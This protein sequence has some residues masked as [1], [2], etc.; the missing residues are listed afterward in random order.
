MYKPG[1]G[2]QRH[3]C[4]SAAGFG[5]VVLGGCG[6]VGLWGAG[7]PGSS[8]FPRHEGDRQQGG[9]PLLQRLRSARAAV[10]DAVHQLRRLRRGVVLQHDHG[11]EGRPVPLLV[12][13]HVPLALLQ[14][15]L[16]LRLLLG[17]PP[18]QPLL[19]LLP[20]RRGH[21]QQEGAGD[22][23]PQPQGA[24]QVE[25][26]QAAGAAVP[27]RVLDGPPARAVAVPAELRR[28]HEPALADHPLELPPGREVVVAAVPLPR[29]RRPGGVRHR[30]GVV[31]GVP[32]QQALADRAL[33]HAA[34]PADHHHGVPGRGRARVV[35]LQHPGPALRRRG[36]LGPVVADP[37][38]LPPRVP[39]HG[40][41]PV[42]PEPGVLPPRVP[43]APGPHQLP[44]QPRGP[45][46]DEEEAQG[47]AQEEQQG[48]RPKEAAG[49]LPG[50][51]RIHAAMQRSADAGRGLERAVEALGRQGADRA[52]AERRR[53]NAGPRWR[54]R[55]RGPRRRSVKGCGRGQRRGCQ[56]DGAHGEHHRGGEGKR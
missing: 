55:G 36:V 51:V 13:R 47:E 5:V 29:A 32:L 25:V 50:P 16:H 1:P 40:E 23:L 15:R 7:L 19:Q 3:R 28:L 4:C 6:A 10:D 46:V 24:L 37:G 17:P 39:G 21:V 44:R 38:E 8:P 53:W 35:P 41:A 31:R 14:P 18:P 12:E 56:R 45:H 52:R 42:G 26:Q 11:V 43:R 30:E 22:L 2:L 49:G 33:A 34:G 27:G 20:V 54:R 9:D 48:L